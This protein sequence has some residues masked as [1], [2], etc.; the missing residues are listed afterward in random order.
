[1]YLLIYSYIM[2]ACDVGVCN[3]TSSQAD[4]ALYNCVR[5]VKE[6]KLLRVVYPDF[7]KEKCI[8]KKTQVE[9]SSQ[10]KLNLCEEN[11]GKLLSLINRGGSL[12]GILQSV[13]KQYLV[14]QGMPYMITFEFFFREKVP[15]KLMLCNSF[16]VSILYKGLAFL[17]PKGLR[18]IGSN[19]PYDLSKV[20]LILM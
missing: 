9:K 11:R 18:G 4:R 2:A 6:K 17:T 16:W 13:T 8:D 19:R 1:M 3:F 15:T 20:S 7:W 14:R 10:N 12:C 5:H